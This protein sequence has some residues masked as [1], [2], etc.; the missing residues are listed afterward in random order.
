MFY[1]HVQSKSFTFLAQFLVR[2]VSADHAF[3]STSIRVTQC[4]E[5]DARFIFHFASPFTSPICI[6]SR[7]QMHVA[8]ETAICRDRPVHSC[9]GDSKILIGSEYTNI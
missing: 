3:P 9:T 1:F 5:H 6:R 4:S 2:V 7:R 8:R